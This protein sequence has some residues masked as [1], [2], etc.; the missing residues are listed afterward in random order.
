MSL[1]FVIFKMTSTKDDVTCIVLSRYCTMLSIVILVMY[2]LKS[3][4]V[5]RQVMHVI[6]VPVNFYYT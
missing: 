6:Y 2:R 5:L 1:D 4:Q 3:S